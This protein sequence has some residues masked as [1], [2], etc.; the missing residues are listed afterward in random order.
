M[1]TFSFTVG[2]KNKAEKSF[3]LIGWA[4]HDKLITKV[5]LGLIRITATARAATSTNAR[6]NNHNYNKKAS[7]VESITMKE[8]DKK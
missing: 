1:H 8:I 4:N 6:N 2:Y 7:T 3:S 5:L